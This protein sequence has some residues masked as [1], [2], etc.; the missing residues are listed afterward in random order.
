MK[1]YLFKPNQGRN[2]KLIEGGWS[3]SMDPGLIVVSLVTLPGT[4]V[5]EVCTGGLIFKIQT[6]SLRFNCSFW[7]VYFLI[8]GVTFF[9]L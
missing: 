8:F 6:K 9:H 4:F 5:E 3:C 2:W 7:L 1:K